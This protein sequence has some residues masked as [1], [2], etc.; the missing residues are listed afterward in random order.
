MI[1]PRIIEFIRS[2]WPEAV[3]EVETGTTGDAPGEAY[4]PLRPNDWNEIARQLRDDP[5]LKLDSLQCITGVDL[6]PEANLEIRYNLHSMEHRH[7][8]EIRIEVPKETP[9]LPSVAA[10]WDIAD[11]FEREVYDMYGIRFS[12]HPNLMR[13]LLPDDWEGWP[14]RKD[15]EEPETYHGIVVPK[16]KTGWE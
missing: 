6:G 15:Y 12:G 2:R 10:V 3:P 16:V 4:V 7:H 13:I 11:W 5:A 1:N 9:E 14:L 8:G